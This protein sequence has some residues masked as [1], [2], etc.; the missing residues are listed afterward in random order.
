[1]KACLF[2]L[3][4]LFVSGCAT[5]HD[6]L[7]AYVGKDMQEAVAAYGDPNLAFA[8]GEG[9][10]DFQWV[11]TSSTP[12]TYTISAGALTDPAQQFDPDIKTRSITPT[13][14]GKA[15]TSE[16]VYTMM[17]RWDEETKS[18]I[19]TGYQQPVSGC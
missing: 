15:I 19:V 16:C 2:L 17:T 13:F 11:I 6:M 1:M 8:Q 12:S 5:K 10:R 18:W 14:D 7:Q 9:R 3:M 4:T